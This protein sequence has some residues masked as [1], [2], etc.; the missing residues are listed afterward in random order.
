MIRLTI[1]GEQRGRNDNNIF[2]IANTLRQIMEPP[3]SRN[4]DIGVKTSKA[5]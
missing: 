1:S 2:E 3:A 4:I 5:K